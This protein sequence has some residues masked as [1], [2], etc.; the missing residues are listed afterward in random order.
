[1]HDGTM[2][3]FELEIVQI[4]VSGGLVDHP[5]NEVVESFDMT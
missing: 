5:C 3:K 4:A 2:A 1:M